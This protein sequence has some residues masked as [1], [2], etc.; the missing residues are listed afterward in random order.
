MT[1]QTAATRARLIQLGSRFAFPLPDALMAII[2]A[3]AAAVG[4]AGMAG[5]PGRWHGRRAA[6][7]LLGLVL[8]LDLLPWGRSLL[9]AGHPSLFYPRTPFLADLTRELAAPGGP[10]RVVGAE[11]LVYPS[12]LPFYGLAEVR[13]HNPLAPMAYLTVLSAAFGFHPSM[14][15]YFSPFRNVD[16]PLLDFLNARAVVGSV[17]MP[18]SRTLALADGG[19][20]APFYLYRNPDAL[21]R[22]FVPTGYEVI[23]RGEVA[24][25]VAAMRDPARVALFADEVGAWRPEGLPARPRAL[26]PLAA[27]P[28]HLDLALPEPAGATLVATSIP[29]S[30]GWRARAARRLLPTLTVDG[31]FLGVKL[32][33]GVKRF[34]LR[35]TPPGFLAGLAAFLVSAAAALLCI[36]RQLRTRTSGRR[37]GRP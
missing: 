22:W 3:L 25:F 1:D 37:A 4:F 10:Y 30:T 35:F 23:G 31:A 9:P 24:R 20:Y 28:G 21:P 13:P 17:A 8:L 5:L 2:L 29:Y 15:E 19:R 27:V 16:H 26:T 14:I 6:G 33:P 18:P 12:L 7:L 32:P 34:E 11:Y 36:Y